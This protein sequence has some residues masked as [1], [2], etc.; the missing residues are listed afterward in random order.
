MNRFSLYVAFRYLFSKKKHH[1]INW[2]SGVAICGVSLT[3]LALVCTLSVFNGFQDMATGFFTSF[4]PQLRISPATG[5]VLH[6]N[7]TLLLKL[8]KNPQIAIWSPTLQEQA[9]VKYKDQQAMVT[10]K[11][12]SDNFQQL[13]E[14]DSI[15]YGNG[16]YK[17]YDE[18]VQY[19][20]MGGELTSTLGCGLRFV[21]PLQVYI[22]KREGRVNMASPQSSFRN[23]YL[24]SPGVVFVVNLQQYDAHYI[25]SSIGFLRDLLDYTDEASDIGIR[26]VPDIDLASAQKKIS[27][28][29]GDN[30]IVENQYQQQHDIFRVMEIE[31]IISY[32]FLSFILLV[33]SFNVIGSIS[34]MIIDKKDDT[35][36]LRHLGCNQKQIAQVFLYIGRLICIIGAVSGI[37]LGIIICLIQ[38]HYGII[39][40][41]NSAA[42]FAITAYPVQVQLIDVIIIFITVIVIGFIAVWWPIQRLSKANKREKK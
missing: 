10:I 27:R 30:Y 37:I 22:P 23:G 40:L 13:N 14:I 24:Y 6:T 5:K 9:M 18:V 39:T 33:A 19:G 26:L 7:D 31:K 1:A 28:F 16:K 35:K 8:K 34:M 25:I 20:I 11:G 4:D 15:L 3:T 29:L 17:L 2:I 42:Q 32:I 21:D 12:V 36:T 38:Q 41:G